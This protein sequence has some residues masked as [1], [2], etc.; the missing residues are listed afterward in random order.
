[1]TII[2][3]LAASGL[4][5]VEEVCLLVLSY[6]GSGL[7]STPDAVVVACLAMIVVGILRRTDPARRFGRALCWIMIV[8]GGIGLAAT[9]RGVQAGTTPIWAAGMV[10]ANLV[11]IG[12]VY[13]GLGRPSAREYLGGTNL[14]AAREQ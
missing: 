8:L 14:G 11:L 13:H 2:L 6:L 5:I 7:F 3:V 10:I 12:A 4:L 9:I 1:M